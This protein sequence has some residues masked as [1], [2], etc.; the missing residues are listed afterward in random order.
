MKSILQER[1]GRCFLCG[2]NA[3][4]DPLDLH[5]VYNAA[6]KKASE[7]YGLLVYLHHNQCHIFGKMSVHGNAKVDRRLKAF[8]QRKAMR[9]YGWTVSDF[10]EIFHKNY[11]EEEQ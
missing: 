9:H 3:G 8:C 7:K 11:L 10:I 5:H 4:I 2:K 1:D 6:A